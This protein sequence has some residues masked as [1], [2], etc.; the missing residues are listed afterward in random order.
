MTV[1][2]ISCVCI[3][4]SS[5]VGSV[6]VNDQ[7]NVSRSVVVAFPVSVIRSRLEKFWTAEGVPKVSPP[8]WSKE[9]NPGNFW[10]D[11]EIM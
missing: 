3:F 1:F 10:A 4:V 5:Y 6:E 2:L 9:N 7:A 11:V 8:N